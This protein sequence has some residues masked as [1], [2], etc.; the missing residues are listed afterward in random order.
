MLALIQ[1][2]PGM[3]T[4]AEVLPEVCMSAVNFSEVVAQLNQYD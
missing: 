4:L 2:E 3:E 1:G